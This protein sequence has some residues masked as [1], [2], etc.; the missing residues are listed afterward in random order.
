MERVR[1]VFVLPFHRIRRRT[2]FHALVLSPLRANDVRVTRGETQGLVFASK[3]DDDASASASASSSSRV[4]EESIYRRDRVQRCFLQRQTYPVHRQRFATR[5]GR[6][7]DR[8]RRRRLGGERRGGDLF[9][10]R[11]IQLLLSISR[12][13]HQLGKKIGHNFV[14]RHHFARLF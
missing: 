6:Q 12:P 13:V 1:D 7:M 11:A 5:R 4:Y 3:E 8:A 2:I 14:S 9:R 10:Q